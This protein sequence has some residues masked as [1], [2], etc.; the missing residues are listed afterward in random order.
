MGYFVISIHLS[1]GVYTYE[2]IIDL[3]YESLVHL[4]NT[5]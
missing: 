4:W 2:K 5:Y 3:N 1:Q